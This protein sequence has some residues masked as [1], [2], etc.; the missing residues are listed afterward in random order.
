M[1]HED[2]NYIWF[3]FS[4]LAL[5][6]WFTHT[7]RD[8]Y[9]V[10][11][12]NVRLC[13]GSAKGMAHTVTV[14]W[15]RGGRA[16]WAVESS[17][18][19]S[20][21]ELE[22]IGMWRTGKGKEEQEEKEEGREQVWWWKDQGRLWISTAGW[23]KKVWLISLEP[24]ASGCL[25]DIQWTVKNYVDWPQGRVASK[26]LKHDAHSKFLVRL[27]GMSQVE[28]KIY[29]YLSDGEPPYYLCFWILKKNMSSNTR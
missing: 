3:F 23:N 15:I 21:R 18:E 22:L 24:S 6:L 27:M 25:L 17:G 19:S 5:A 14:F 28:S 10:A 29:I 4:S 1:A 13:F 11:Q 26:F 8:S 20:Y 16:P 12:W 9:L 7:N 2:S